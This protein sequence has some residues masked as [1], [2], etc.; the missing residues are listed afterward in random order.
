MQKFNPGTFP[1]IQI[2][3]VEQISKIEGVSLMPMTPHWNAENFKQRFSVTNGT[4]Q[5]EFLLQIDKNN[6]VDFILN[7]ENKCKELD[8][9]GLIEHVLYFRDSKF[10]LM[11][12]LEFSKN[13]KRYSENYF[14]VFDNFNRSKGVIEF[15]N[16]CIDFF[17]QGQ[18][19]SFKPS[20][21]NID[22]IFNEFKSFVRTTFDKVSEVHDKTISTFEYEFSNYIIKGKSI[23]ESNSINSNYILI[24]SH[25]NKIS[26]I[27]IVS[28]LENR[29]FYIDNTQIKKF[30]TFMSSVNA[31]I[32]ESVYENFEN[33]R[34][35]YNG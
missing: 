16:N 5:F 13:L 6:K 23:E 8:T 18:K 35:L 30:D 34:F 25:G 4:E 2:F 20:D 19:Q 26:D 11:F 15:K 10:K 17:H 24:D 29:L 21:E 7:F 22:I 1:Q 12:L 31:L 14:E 9:R 28:D 32:R 3:I 27:K 33:F